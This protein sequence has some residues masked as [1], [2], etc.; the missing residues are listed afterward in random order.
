MMSAREAPLGGIRVIDLTRLLPGPLGTQYLADMGAEV[1]K[2][3]HPDGGDYARAALDEAPGEAA[4]G[5]AVKT[6]AFFQAVNRSKHSVTLD[7]TDAGQ[8]QKLFDLVRDADVLVESFRPGV[9]ARLGFGYPEMSAINPGLIYVS[10]TGYGQ[11]GT[12]S[13]KAGHDL[14]YLGYSGLLDQLRDRHGDPVIPGVQIADVFGGSLHGVVAV[15]TGLV[16]RQQ[17]GRGR[18]ID[19]AMTECCK[20]LNIGPMTMSRGPGSLLDGGFACYQIYRT[21]DNQH[22]TI[23]AAEPKF[24]HNLCAVLARPDLELHQFDVGRQPWLKA[25]LAA[26]FAEHTL[27]QWCARLAEADCCFGPV[28]SVAEAMQDAVREAGPDQVVPAAL[29]F[30]LPI[31][32]SDHAPD[33]DAVSPG[34]GEQ[35]SRYFEQGDGPPINHHA[36]TDHGVTP[37]LT[38]GAS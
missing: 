32:I 5:E 38:G 25:E 9:A 29:K 19:V 6:S 12:L 28:L 14:N 17:S 20:S 1:I 36:A 24:W 18:Y 21:S 33:L 3:E 7:L 23:G 34:L 11:S 37:A 2:V 26:L 16:S 15:L 4:P 10:I 35:N 8:R 31:R 30:G 22:L 27:A 13:G